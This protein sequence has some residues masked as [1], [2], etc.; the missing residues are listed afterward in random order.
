MS[1]MKEY[2]REYVKQNKA[3]T[4][5]ELANRLSTEKNIMT[6]YGSIKSTLYVVRKELDIKPP[7]SEAEIAIRNYVKKHN[8]CVTF[9]EVKNYILNKK[10]IKLTEKTIH[11]ILRRVLKESGGTLRRS[12]IRQIIRE[13]VIKQNKEVSFSEVKNHVVHVKNI[14][15]K[16]ATIRNTLYFVRKELD[17][18]LKS[19]TL[20]Q[21]IRDYV[22]T[23]EN[24][25]TFNEVKNHIWFEKNIR[26]TD[27]SI[28]STLRQVLN[29]SGRTIKGTDVAEVIRD[30]LK[31]HNGKVTISEV[32]YY[33]LVQKNIK[34]TRK[35]V[36][37]TFY[38]VRKEFIKAKPHH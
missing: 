37:S 10:R 17:V 35:T 14:K 36:E 15:A 7:L 38:K 4:I 26:E 32:G 19:T 18:E 31:Q 8:N 29:E 33:V 2:I 12:G 23:H 25:V 27:A 1:T 28:R 34:T 11:E 24:E 3:I 22:K 21:V 9:E 5:D 13:Y 20:A 16:D 6:S 30:Y